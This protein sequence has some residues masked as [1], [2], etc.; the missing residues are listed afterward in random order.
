[1][2]RSSIN[3]GIINKKKAKR[4]RAKRLFLTYPQCMTRPSMVMYRI[5]HLFEDNLEWAVVASEKHKDGNPHLHCVVYLKRQ[6]DTYDHTYLDQLTGKHGNYQVARNM[7]NTLRYVTKDNDY[8][9]TEGFDVDAYLNTSSNKKNTKM[10]IVANRIKEEGADVKD[11]VEEYPGI[12]LMHLN[13]IIAF[14]QFINAI[15]N[16][17]KLEWY[18]I[19]ELKCNCGDTRLIANWLNKNIK[20]ERKFKQPQLYV[21]GIPNTGKTTMINN[22][23][24]YVR[25]YRLPNEDF[26]DDY[27]D[28]EYDLIVIDEFKG[29]KKQTFMN[30]LLDGQ[31]MQMPKKGSQYLKKQ[32]L[33]VI[34]LSNYSLDNAYKNLDYMA[35]Q[36]LDVRLFI[37]EVRQFIKL[38]FFEEDPLAT[39]DNLVNI[40][41]YPGLERSSSN[42]STERI[43]ITKE[44]IDKEPII[45]NSESIEETIADVQPEGMYDKERSNTTDTVSY[46][47]PLMDE[48]DRDDPDYF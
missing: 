31:P 35:A 26:Y 21:F 32:N 48:E 5:K 4:F 7:V 19:D 44:V 33:P 22:L 46:E 38:P 20:V 13:K 6:L 34:V 2:L 1:M 47:S 12:S 45:V 16:E 30:K 11:I 9:T 24:K 17:D 23:E 40:F 29:Q 41:G 3:T 43:L 39:F 42:D 14:K 25:V 37:V 8:I 36:A 28:K 10:D 18:G 27:Y 15:D